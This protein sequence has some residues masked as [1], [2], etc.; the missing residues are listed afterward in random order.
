M[1]YTK[2]YIHRRDWILDHYN[3]LRLRPET[4]LIVSFIDYANQ[5]GLPL[6]NAWL[7]E[8]TNMKMEVLDQAISELIALKILKIET[9]RDQIDFN[10][11][12]IFSMSN[13]YEFVA[14]DLLERFEAE[15]ARPLSQNEMVRLNEL[16]SKYPENAIIYGLKEAF[17]NG[18]L[19][20]SYIEKVVHASEQSKIS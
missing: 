3:Q 14:P 2:G 13:P 5:N 19:S 1:W 10:I 9:N 4:F 17:V 15:F 8:K 7:A 18:K 20:M 11:D 16:R 12:S 6:T